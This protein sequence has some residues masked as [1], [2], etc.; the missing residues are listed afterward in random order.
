MKNKKIYRLAPMILAAGLLLS[1]CVRRDHSGHPYGFVYDYLAVPTQHL[2]HWMANVLHGYG[3]SIIVITLVVRLV[4]M[5]LMVY[6]SKKATVQQ[7]KLSAI[8]PALDA[9]QKRQKNAKTPEERAA[10]SADM[11]KLYRDNGISM[12]GGIGCLP[13]LIQLPIFSALYAAIQYSPEI[14]RSYFFGVNLGQRSF[15]YV[16][17]TFLIYALQGWIST[18]GLPED[19]KQQMKQ[20]MLI[21]PIMTA[22]FTYVSP[23][24]LGLYFFVGGIVACI[25]TLIVNAMRPQIRKRVQAQMAEVKKKN[26]IAAAAA[27]KQAKA[28]A[29]DHNSQPKVSQTKAMHA[30]NRKRNAG[31]Q[32]RNK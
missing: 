16:L 7:E 28:A 17:L 31:K 24:G 27:A 25:Q 32:H 14:S 9:I 12:T 11:M 30:N 26:A 2:L 22:A 5:P 15:I 18:L 19:Q 8:R 10:V 6:Q 23:A 1:G 4:L 20:M 13:L 21:S 29:A 3:W